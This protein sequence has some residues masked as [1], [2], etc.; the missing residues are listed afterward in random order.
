VPLECKGLALDDAQRCEQSPTAE[1]PC[2]AR[3]EPSLLD[4]NDM[5]AV[6]YLPM[7]HNDLAYLACLSAYAS[8]VTHPRHEL[9]L[10]SLR[11]LT[12]A[13]DLEN[14][15]PG[16]AQEFDRFCGEMWPKCV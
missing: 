15:K 9:R 16:N 10:Y 12:A 6:K 1:Q 13:V 5:P 7:D 14:R 3:R 2:L 8:I 4:R 11:P